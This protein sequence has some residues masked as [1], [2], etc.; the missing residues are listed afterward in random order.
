MKPIISLFI[1]SFIRLSLTAQDNALNIDDIF[2]EKKLDSIVNYKQDTIS[3]SELKGKILI[4]DFWQRSCGSCISGMPAM[5]ELQKKFHDDVRIFYAT[6]ERKKDVE[7]FLE[8]R[9]ELKNLGLPII[10]GAHKLMD[11]FPHITVP[12]VVWIGKDRKVK[13]ITFPDYLTEKNISNLLER[14]LIRLPVKKD[15]YTDDK[16]PLFVNA[17]QTAQNIIFSSTLT[18]SMDGLW[19]GTIGT[20]KM[21]DNRVKLF[22]YNKALLYLYS[23]AYRFQIKLALFNHSNLV[24]NVKNDSLFN[25]SAN[26][27]EERHRKSFCYELI[28]PENS[29]FH[30]MEKGCAYMQ[31]DL[32][33]YFNLETHIE[34]RSLDCYVIIP[35]DSVNITSDPGKPI[36]IENLYNAELINQPV[37]SLIS[38]LDIYFMSE[39][40]VLYEG[41]A[42][43]RISLTVSKKITSLNSIKNDLAQ[44]GLIIRFLTREVDVLVI[45]DKNEM[46]VK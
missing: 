26:D 17:S 41:P 30:D 38:F 13:A 40:P 19:S 3:L 22:A 10:T 32:D 11:Q 9:K 2:P 46:A 8:K 12:H 20:I 5:A 1:F 28:M 43:K 4:I 39:H 29:F 36:M 14:N 33:R 18:K 35:I 44:Q 25:I 27:P 31:K 42:S 16:Q 6:D 7:E 21:G 15:I 45:S 37:S 23:F 24:F 34:K